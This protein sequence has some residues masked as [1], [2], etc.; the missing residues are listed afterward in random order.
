MPNARN[1]GKKVAILFS[2]VGIGILCVSIWAVASSESFGEEDLQTVITIG[3]ASGNISGDYHFFADHQ[4]NERIIFSTKEN[5]ENFA[6]IEIEI[7]DDDDNFG[8]LAGEVLFSLDVF[9]PKKTFI[10]TADIGSGIPTR[11]ILFRYKGS[12]KHF[13]IKESG[14]DGSLSLIEFTPSR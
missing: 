6:Y 4:T 10:V 9:S 13:Y 8:L 3:K 1:I 11:G 14:M 7:S 5:L 2:I 12:V